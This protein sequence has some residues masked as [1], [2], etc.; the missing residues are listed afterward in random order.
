MLLHPYTGERKGEKQRTGT[1]SGKILKKCTKYSTLFFL[2]WEIELLAYLLSS[3]HLYVLWVFCKEHKHACAHTNTHTIPV[4]PFG[5]KGRK[6]EKEGEKGRKEERKNGRERWRI[7]WGK[8]AH[9]SLKCH[10][11]LQFPSSFSI[12]EYPA[13]FYWWHFPVTVIDYSTHPVSGT[14]PFW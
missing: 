3:L 6:D 1:M 12:P 13:P 4:L 14:V 5:R 7:W 10:L 9:R 8:L 11:A 2:L